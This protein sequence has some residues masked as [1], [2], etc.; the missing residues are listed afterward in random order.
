VRAQA[1]KVDCRFE[2]HDTALEIVQALKVPQQR[3]CNVSPRAEYVDTDLTNLR[4][5]CVCTRCRMGMRACW[6]VV[7]DLEMVT[8]GQVRFKDCSPGVPLRRMFR[9]F[10]RSP[11]TER[12]D[13]ITIAFSL[14]LQSGLHR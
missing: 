7:I 12:S 10:A 3:F 13:L 14:L 5:D 1:G 2:F 11:N 9:C 6:S 8:I 4:R